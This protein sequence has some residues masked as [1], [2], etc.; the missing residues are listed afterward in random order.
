M[1]MSITNE[2]I[3]VEMKKGFGKIDKRL[4]VVEEDIRELKQDVD[5]LVKSSVRHDN[6]LKGLA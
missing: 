6:A 4:T 1:L 2:H 5:A 3:L